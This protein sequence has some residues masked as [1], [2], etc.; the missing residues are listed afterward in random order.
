M[1]LKTT[2]IIIFGFT[3]LT[4][5]AQIGMTKTEALEAYSENFSRESKTSSG[6]E[7]IILEKH[8]ENKISGKFVQYKAIYFDLEIDGNYM[9]S[10]YKIIEPSSEVN[11]WIK[12]LKE[13]NYVKLSDLKYK[14]YEKS[15][16][17][18]VSVD[19]DACF[20]NVYFDNK[21]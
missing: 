16:I 9:C 17:Y 11:N 19:D 5:K 13:S 12:V 21:L 8:L 4:T 18:E 14:D 2:L 3:F 7:Y 6:T 10:S 15:L 20:L 1:K